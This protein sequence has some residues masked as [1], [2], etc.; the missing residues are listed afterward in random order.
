MF[1]SSWN[2]SRP[3]AGMLAFLVIFLL[4]TKAA[5]AAQPLV[6]SGGAESYTLGGQHLDVFEDE[7]GRL[8]ITDVA[9]PGFAGAFRRLHQS[10]PNFGMTD[11]AFWF[12]FTVDPDR[13]DRR[14]WLLHVDQPLIDEVD[15]YIARGDGSFDVEISGDTRPAGSRAAPGRDIRL[16][17][18]LADG[19]RT[20]YL[21]VW[22][23]GRAI[24]PFTVLTEN[25]YRKTA[26]RQRHIDAA[27][28][29]FLFAVF[30]LGFL[31]FLLLKDPVYLAYMIYVLGILLS[32]LM[33]H[34]YLPLPAVPAHPW[35]H[36]YAKAL[37]WSI[38]ILA[39]AVFARSF[40]KTRSHSP[41]L[42]RLLKWFILLYPI[43]IVIYPLIPPL[44]G[45]KLI[46]AALFAISL[47]TLVSAVACYRK[48]FS[49]A[50]YFLYSRCAIYVGAMLFS[51]VNMGFLPLNFFT[52]NIYLLATTLDV[53]FVSLALADNFRAMNRRITALVRDLRGEV[54]ERIA[55]NRALEA[56]M[57][58][59]KRLEREIV[60]IS[61]EERRRISQELH[62]GLCQQ[63]TGARLR[64]AALED[65]F[66][67]AGLDTEVRPLGRLLEKMVDDA[68][69][70]SRGRWLT[71]SSGRGAMIN[72][73]D[74]AGQ[75]AEESGIRIELAQK[76]DCA[77]CAG[78]NLTQVHHIAREAMR[79]AVKHSRA[80]RIKVL[81]ECDQARGI[82]LEVEDNGQGMAGRS[83][84]GGGMGIR[85][86][87]HR[88]EMIG[89]TLQI[90][91]ADG[92][93]TLVVCNAPCR[94]T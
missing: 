89:G 86:M 19:S 41:H 29:G 7:T 84:N 1:S 34:G 48:G 81:L 6:L 79:N 93:G 30:S 14:H 49:A 77:S 40:L 56:Q 44:A 3:T 17:L 72:L 73:Q 23:P 67:A 20:F 88:S 55:A 82:F 37:V 8:R 75:L 59:R 90:V 15:L 10:I 64:F 74:L 71:D 62:D 33:I 16:P 94:T 57:A 4:F 26:S 83:G 45:K 65:R 42:D 80:T 91:D 87:K 21:R 5:S 31:L 12:R 58:E 22:V 53:V 13:S 27:Y 52:G 32:M 46:N 24:F 60:K 68:Y 61:D 78:E 11:A 92:G 76:Q 54:N 18:P 38:P 2:F 85:I 50:L 43:F 51:L 66:A 28:G 35:L 69:R 63:L 47:L 9:S 25:A 70:L 36:H 39:G